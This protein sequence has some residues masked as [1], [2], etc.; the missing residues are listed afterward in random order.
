MVGAVIGGWLMS[1]IDETGVDEFSL[2]SIGMAALG[3]VVFLLVLQAI[4]GIGPRRN[5][6]RDQ[7][8][9][10][11]TLG[12]WHPASRDVR[13]PLW[14]TTR[15]ADVRRSGGGGFRWAMSGSAG[16]VAVRSHL[17]PA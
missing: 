13:A 12:A 9:Q 10:Y 15:G 11:V 4:S 8:R 7:P 6:R 3:A 1:L 5:R 14:C 2:R 17:G 16:G